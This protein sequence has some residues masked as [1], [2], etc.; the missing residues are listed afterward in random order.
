M[1]WRSSFRCLPGVAVAAFVLEAVQAWRGEAVIASDD[2]SVAFFIVA[3]IAMLSVFQ[4]ARLDANAGS[5]VIHRRKPRP[6]TWWKGRWNSETFCPFG[7]Y[8]GVK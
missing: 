8:T 3:G 2:F 7:P 6:E 4:F 1:R 5:S